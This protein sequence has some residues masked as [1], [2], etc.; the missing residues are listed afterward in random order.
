MYTQD[1]VTDL[2]CR[3]TYSFLEW[4]IL[5]I[6]DKHLENWPKENC[7][8]ISC[9][10]KIHTTVTILIC[11][12]CGILSYQLY[13]Q[14]Q[15]LN[16]SLML[17]HLHFYLNIKVCTLVNG[18]DNTDMTGHWYTTGYI[19]LTA[20]FTSAILPSLGYYICTILGYISFHTC[21]IV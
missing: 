5:L 6:T 13:E 2:I 18:L 10:I 15:I 21:H 9:V 4:T 7:F 19:S 16:A 8:W 11:T 20:H 17:T 12:E 3:D 1:V 14:V